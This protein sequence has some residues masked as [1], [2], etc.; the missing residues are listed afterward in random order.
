[1]TTAVVTGAARGLG[2]E[3]AKVLAARGLTVHLT[4]VDGEGAQAAA[5]EIGGRAFAS[6][7]D[8]R[9][10]AACQAVAADTIERTGDLSVW[11]N[12]AGVLFTGPAWEHDDAARRLMIDVNATGTINGTLAALESMRPAN[13]GHVVNVVSMAGV[14]AA[15]RE[16][17][18]AASKHAAIAFSLSTLNDLR[19][20]GVKGVDISCLCPD[21]IWTPMLHD[22]LLDPDAASSFVGT[23]LVPEQVAAHVGRLLDRPRPVTTVPR[24]RGLVARFGDLFPRVM[25]LLAHRVHADGRRKQRRIARRIEKGTWPP[26]R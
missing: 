25:L 24:A 22:R 18:Y 16:A 10:F 6:R 19:L 20:A 14:V 8:V 17:V 9:D 5:A 23:L 11:V 3:I 15:P 21:G 26:R 4:D 1:M 12:N 7:L 2:F 13:R